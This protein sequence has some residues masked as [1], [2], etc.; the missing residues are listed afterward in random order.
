MDVISREAAKA[1]GLK[2][3]Y[4]GV[5]CTR[6][7]DAERKVAS[8][9]CCQCESDRKDAHRKKNP[10]NDLARS[11]SYYA[12]NREARV[13]YAAERI[14]ENPEANR[15]K[16]S[17]WKKA[18][19]KK[20]AEQKRRY[21]EKYPE[22]LTESKRGQKARREASKRGGLMPDRTRGDA[23]KERKVILSAQLI[24]ELS[25]R[26][27][28]CDH[29]V[30]SFG[31]KTSRRD[32]DIWPARLVESASVGRTGKYPEIQSRDR[33]THSKCAG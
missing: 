25:G 31:R 29:I 16:V 30:C 33:G 23:A 13:K 10:E 26:E 5:P 32:P 19:P 21:Y 4:T 18:N 27:Y 6:G 24:S 20:R 2:R 15:D 7:H 8:Y 9:D 28:H 11:K 12:R 17:K 22:K 3:Y 1:K 14:A